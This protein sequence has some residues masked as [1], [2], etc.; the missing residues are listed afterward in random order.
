MVHPGHSVL[1]VAVI[2]FA[3]GVASGAATPAAAP[4]AGPAAATAVQS[5]MDA[6]IQ[7]PTDAAAQPTTDATVQPT[8]TLIVEDGETGE[9]ILAIPVVDGTNVTLAYE[10]SVEKTPVRDVY[11]V[12]DDRLEMIRMEFESF[13]AGLPARANVTKTADGSYAFDPPGS[14]E[15]LYVQPGEV[16]GHRLLVGDREFDLVELSD[17]RTVRLHLADTCG[18]G[19]DAT[20]EES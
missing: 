16:A 10:H 2:A 4:H 11:R 17:G 8:T 15:E 14:Y 6:S 3:A 1:V 12:Q 7:S 19:P 9:P 18:V 20:G 13:G 5:P